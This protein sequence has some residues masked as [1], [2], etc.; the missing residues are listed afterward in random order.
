MSALPAH[1]SLGGP[2]NAAN[3][4]GVYGATGRLGRITAP[5]LARAGRTVAIAGR[6][7]SRIAGLFA[8]SWCDDALAFRP[9]QRELL[10]EFVAPCRV[11][12]N[13]GGP[14]VSVELAW[15]AI[16]AGADFIDASDGLLWP[17]SSRREIH[18]FARERAVALIP[19]AGL[20]RLF[21]DL[22][23]AAV[24]RNATLPGVDVQLAVE[25]E[26]V[27]LRAVDSDGRIVQNT[28][29]AGVS[30]HLVT[31]HVLAEAVRCALD[32]D[33][34]AS[35]MLDATA[36]VP[37]LFLEALPFDD[38]RLPLRRIFGMPMPEDMLL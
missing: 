5:L 19:N 35:G 17:E 24:A 2:A 3:R 36:F 33:I 31:A 15:A 21:V 20:D 18:R 38:L 29:M 6:T 10:R 4:V 25:D 14:L 23:A 13:C 16:E 7:E 12:V 37:E 26:R 22:Y 27:G 1:C 8:Q 11:V 9:S 32:G 30:P 34:L 28:V